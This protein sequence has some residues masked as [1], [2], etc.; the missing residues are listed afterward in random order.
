MITTGTIFPDVLAPVMWTDYLDKVTPVEEGPESGL[1]YKREDRFAP[2]GYGGINGAKLRQCIYLMSLM[3]RDLPVVTGCSVLSPQSSMT[4]LVGRHMGHEVHVMLGAT[5]ATSAVKHENVRIAVQAGAKL[6][7]TK[8][9]YN[10]A[11]QRATSLW[12]QQHNAQ[13]MPYG[14]TTWADSSPAMI[15]RFHEIP[16]TQAI[17]VPD[18]VR[19]VIVPFGSANSAMGVLLA[20][21]RFG[22]GTISRVVLVGIGPN[23]LRWFTQR[24]AAVAEAGGTDLRQR[25]GLHAFG[26]DQ[27]VAQ[28]W[29]G[30]VMLSHYDLHGTGI[31]KYS[32]R[33]PWR[34]DGID[35]HPT[36]EG[37]IMHWLDRTQPYW[38]TPRDG[39]TLFWIVG[40]EPHLSAMEGHL[41]T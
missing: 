38:Y 5:T 27:G 25:Y 30:D 15:R 7:F 6:E 1:L 13:I 36:Y 28:Q 24:A 40:S 4:A 31:F 8:V 10:P 18:G 35:F 3:S 14:I 32:D 11:L 16:L 41:P 37:K 19:T 17:S 39:A 34:Q 9:A 20:L 29:R 26:D 22:P 12:A 33:R 2:L 23:R 21:A